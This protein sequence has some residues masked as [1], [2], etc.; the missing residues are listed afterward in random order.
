MSDD[1]P[2]ATPWWERHVR[3][4]LAPL[5]G[6]TICDVAVV[7]LG[8]SGLAC[9]TELRAR[10]A[11]VVGLDAGVVAGGA[12]GRNG[13]FL[14]GGLADF[15]HDAVAAHGR[16]RAT[17]VYRRTLAEIDR[18]AVETPDAVRR[19]GSLRVA[20]SDDERED[21]ARQLAAM[22]ADDLP[23]EAYD[24]A[25]G[26]GL[27]FPRDAAF[28][29]VAR[30]LALAERAVRAGARLHERTLVCGI[31][32]D[33]RGVEVRTD[34]G[35][36][37]CGAVVVAVDGRLDRVL[38]ELAGTVRTA[39]LQMLATAPVRERVAPCP[40]YSRWGYDYWQQMPGGELLVGGGRDLGGDGEWTE[41]ASPDALVQAALDRLLRETIGV[42]AP[43][44]HR[45]AASVGYT[46]DALPIASEVRPG[47]LGIG[48]YAGTGNVVGA[49]LGRA[50]AAE[51]TGDRGALAAALA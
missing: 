25:E 16:E 10:G 2:T 24:G 35:R 51:A 48:G 21:C 20:A 49:L 26:R 6:D 41:D 38:P 34:R 11:R 37:S 45:W 32:G 7:G 22:R 23:V 43:V 3:A 40:V 13:G 18:I 4:P 30:C 42:R 12:A 1:A 17:R 39:R 50:A 8:G 28:D 29:P 46:C 14:L 36:V 9:V 5:D 33:A 31:A 19:V 44:T 15:H 47:V 27:R